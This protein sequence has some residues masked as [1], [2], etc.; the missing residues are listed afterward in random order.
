[1]SS[2]KLNG[3]VAVISGAGRG[4]GRAIALRLAAEGCDCFLL[5]R[6]ADALRDVANE[7]V[8][9]GVSADWHAVNLNTAEGCQAAAQ[10]VL[11]RFDVVDILVNCAG[12]T[13]AGAF[14]SQADD[15]WLTG[16]ALK[17]HGAVRLSR[18]LWPSLSQ[19]R[20]TVINIGGA[21]VYTPG[22]MF[23]IGGAVN[24]ALAHFTKSLSRQGLV[25]DVNVN[26]VHPG[27]TVSERMEQL[28]QQQAE[29]AGTSV[30]EVMQENVEASGTRR[31]GQPED[32]ANAV[33]FLCDPASRHIQGVG[34]AID[35]GATS[36][37]H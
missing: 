13:K 6:S 22:N 15:D 17:F 25:D 29:A 4:I 7:I 31:L 3:K 26:I 35:G 28:L 12:D 9:L 30:E 33:A 37:F 23:M 16:F 20:G 5:S 34:F 10:T 19:R 36:G 11:E 2:K 1:M 21:A 27:M 8:S 32:V 18:A 14:L 24:A